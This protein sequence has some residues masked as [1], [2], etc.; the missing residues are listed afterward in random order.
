MR[1]I[2]WLT[3][4]RALGCSIVL[5]A[6]IVAIHP[7]LGKYAAGCG[8]IGV[9]LFMVLSGMLLV[10]PYIYSDK[11]FLPKNIVTFYW[12]K[13][14]RLCPAY[15][16]GLAL[17]V[18]AKLSEPSALWDYLLMRNAWGHFW[19]MPVIIKFYALAPVVLLLLSGMKCSF[20][21]DKGTAVFAGV[22]LLI[23]VLLAVAFP[24]TSYEENSIQLV[25]YMPTFIIGMLLA[26]ALNR[27]QIKETVVCDILLPIPILGILILT[28]LSREILFGVEPGGY[29]QNKYLYM[30]VMWSVIIFLCFKSRYAKK[31]LE[32]SVV[33]NILGDLSY[34]IYL[35]HYIILIYLHE[36]WDISVF[37]NGVITILITLVFSKIIK[38]VECKLKIQ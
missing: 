29:L 36:Y 2:G 7:Y 19:Y 9:W 11:L 26:I 22:I 35:F 32:R 25:W 14:C 1:K 23:G 34:Y 10:Y 20:G 17:L 16:C 12:K 21:K 8:K 13:A 30:S 15:L 33:G 3:S 6:H 37:T 28:P 4:L 24:F 38:I 5:L 27:I 31:W 18:A